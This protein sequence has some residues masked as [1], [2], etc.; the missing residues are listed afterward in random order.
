VNGPRRGNGGQNRDYL[1]DD[2]HYFVCCLA[3]AKQSAA[4]EHQQEKQS[5]RGCDP[6]RSRGGLVVDHRCQSEHNYQWTPLCF[7]FWAED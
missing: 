2:L 4:D 6:P 3:E 7:G 1:M 5:G